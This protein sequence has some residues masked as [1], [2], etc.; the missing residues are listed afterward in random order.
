MKCDSIGQM[1]WLT[2]LASISNGGVS[3]FV[4]PSG[5][6][7]RLSATFT[8]TQLQSSSISPPQTTSG[9]EEGSV[10]E[11]ARAERSR[12]AK[13]TWST[14]ALSETPNISKT[15]DLTL[16]SADNANVYDMESFKDFLQLKG[17]YF[18]NGL[19]SCEIGDRLIHPFEAH[20]YV[21]SLSFD[22]E[23][24]LHYKAKIVDTPLTVQERSLNKPLAKG[25]MSSLLDVNNVLDQI[26]L[27]L[28]PI[29]RDTANLVANVWPPP[30][31]DAVKN[32]FLEP[33]L[34]VATDNGSPFALDLNTLE[35]KGLLSFV[36]KE[37]AQAGGSGLA[38]LNDS[39]DVLN[40]NEI[41]AHARYDKRRDRFIMCKSKFD[42]PGEANRGNTVLEFLEF[43]SSFRLVSSRRFKTRFMVMHDWMITDQYYVVPKN[44]AKLQWGNLGKFVLGKAL[45]VDIFTMDEECVS[46]LV[47]IPRHAGAVDNDDDVLEVKADNFFTVFHFGPCFEPITECGTRTN[48]EEGDIVVYSSIFDSYDF[49]GEMGFD[50][51]TQEFDPIAWSSSKGVPAPRF[52]KFVI[53][54]GV[55]IHRERLPLLDKN[56]EDVPVDMLT[57]AGDGERCRYVY[58]L[59]ASREEGEI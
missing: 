12:I 39:A 2:V 17:T 40:T 44:P 36:L 54:D 45:G 51:L 8:K 9:V 58:G 56:G 20:G 21:K 38:Y 7:T 25:V 50:A 26:K 28:S 34:I 31:S 47:F 30:E 23:G 15:M 41:L 32:G 57:F 53:R 29:D 19:A 22:G 49:G 10:S 11:A 42:I 59:G 6:T 33:M 24:K 43:D 4:V 55:L 48:S 18:M 52:D 37:K 27:M 16:P 1:L 35:M 14:I 13:Q 46:E 3:F 5:P